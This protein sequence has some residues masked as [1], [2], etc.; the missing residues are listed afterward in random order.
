MT[1]DVHK[2]VMIRHLVLGADREAVM[3]LILI[4]A[5]LVYGIGGIWFKL[6]IAAFGIA[7][8][9]GLRAL[10]RIDPWYVPIMIRSW[11]LVGRYPA[12]GCRQE[13]G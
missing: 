9:A 6:T 12:R 13:I 5:V 8:V 7:G 10:A 4:V 11:Q 3:S 1:A 2:S